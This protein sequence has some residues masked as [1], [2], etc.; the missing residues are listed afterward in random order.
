MFYIH[1]YTPSS[2]YFRMVAGFGNS[3][4]EGVDLGTFG[5]ASCRGIGF[6]SQRCRLLW[7][8]AT[9]AYSTCAKEPTVC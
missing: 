3:G 8:V 2:F 5:A 6:G 7:L 1:M 9:S 4:V